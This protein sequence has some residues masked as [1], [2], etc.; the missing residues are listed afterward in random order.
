MLVALNEQTC[1]F[2]GTA[3]AEMNGAFFFFFFFTDQIVR[4]SFTLF[5]SYMITKALILQRCG[6]K[7][8][9]GG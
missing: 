5:I 6:D 9:G 4:A 8:C 3:S 7:A 1:V 2:C